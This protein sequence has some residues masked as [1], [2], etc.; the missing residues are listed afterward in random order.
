MHAS[1]RAFI[2][3]YTR[4]ERE[5]GRETHQHPDQAHVAEAA[6]LYS[7]PSSLATP[8]TPVSWLV[9]DTVNSQLSSV[10]SL[11]FKGSMDLT[12][13]PR[14]FAGVR[15]GYELPCDDATGLFHLSLDGVSASLPGPRRAPCLQSAAPQHPTRR[16]V[17][18]DTFRDLSICCQACAFCTQRF[19]VPLTGS[20]VLHLCFCCELSCHDDL[21]LRCEHKGVCLALAQYQQML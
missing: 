20:E 13:R 14:R 12:P 8:A 5:G 11:S 17:D 2:N 19:A 15:R 1:M 16:E 10:S 18:S 21:R 9:E 7:M 6:K 3:T 4:G